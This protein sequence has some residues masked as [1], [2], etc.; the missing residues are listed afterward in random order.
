MIVAVPSYVARIAVVLL[1]VALAATLA[2]FSVRNARAAHNAG[3]LTL[4]GYE[5]A[6]RLEPTD[7]RNW[8]LLGHYLQ[9][10]LEDPDARRA[11]QCYLVSLKLDP[12]AATTWLDLA[13][14]YESEGDID[15]ARDAFLQASRVYPLSA[16][17]SWRYGNFLLRQDQLPQ[18]F[19]QM[20]RSVSVDPHRAAQAFS[21]SWRVD[22]DINAIL[23]QVLPPVPSVYLD[24]IRELT[25]SHDVAPALVIWDRL[26]ALHPSPSIGLQDAFLL[27][28]ALLEAKHPADARRVWNQAVILAHL[29]A[30][31][32]PPASVLWDGGF[33][34]SEHNGGFAWSFGPLSAGAQ[35]GLDTS[36]KRSGKQSL[37]VTFDGREN[38]N[39]ADIC[40]AAI[41]QPATPYRFSAWLRAQD[42][43]TSQGVRFRLLWLQDSQL[44]SVETPEVH[45]TQPW[46]QIDLPWLAPSDVRQVRICIARN[47]SDDFG[48][49][50]QGTAWV[51]DVSLAPALPA[52]PTRP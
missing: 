12:R 34:T 10:N 33:E 47:P 9:Y 15:S 41:V 22:P 46:T 28:D 2:F 31:L 17:V 1:S 36:I 38:V 25:A 29:P 13:A 32:D 35:A 14:A 48:S 30:S 27:T 26:A 39:F 8:Y 50:I 20:R 42:L 16:E 7:S 19:A 4:K 49:R 45:G 18:A 11:I 44:H 3:L 37:R 40:Q 43:T 24:S 51:D 21:R 23:D 5:T 6:I 52:E